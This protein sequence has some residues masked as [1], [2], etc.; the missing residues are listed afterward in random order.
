MYCNDPAFY[1]SEVSV[2]RYTTLLLLYTKMAAGILADNSM[3]FRVHE[4]PHFSGKKCLNSFPHSLSVQ[5]I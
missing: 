2:N 3:N 1:H 4:S 5:N